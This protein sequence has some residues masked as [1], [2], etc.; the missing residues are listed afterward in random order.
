VPCD[1][2]AKVFINARVNML[3]HLVLFVFFATIRCAP[4][5]F[6]PYRARLAVDYGPRLVGLATCDPFGNIKPFCS[7]PNKGDLVKLSRQILDKARVDGATEVLVGLPLDSNGIMSYNLR[8]FNGQLCL[9]F[10]SVLSSIAGAELPRCRIVLVDERYTTREAKVRMK[11]ERIRASLDAMSAACLLQRYM[12]DKGE[13]ALEAAACAYPPPPELADFDYDVVR[14]YI[15]DTHFAS[16]QTVLQR[17]RATMQKLKN[18]VLRNKN[19]IYFG[20]EI[21]GQEEQEEPVEE[22]EEFDEGEGEGEDEEE[23]EGE[24]REEEKELGVEDEDEKREREEED[25]DEEEEEEDEEEEEEDDELARM[26]QIRSQRRKKGTL[27]KK[28]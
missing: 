3:L 14:Q 7:L 28:V 11:A 13:G 15:R 21:R 23:G 20:D 19:S 8:N 26:M 17:K 2:N 25:E 6:Q 16:P 18:G 27:R 22:D 10:S 12:E 24:D 5:E 9:A 1:T 4:I